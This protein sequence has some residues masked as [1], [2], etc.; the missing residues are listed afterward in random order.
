MP[1][2][3]PAPTAAEPAPTAAEPDPDR[4]AI[5]DEL[6]ASYERVRHAVAQH[7]RAGP[8]APRRPGQAGQT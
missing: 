1:D 4:A 2:P 8:G 7:D 5:W 3:E 6:W